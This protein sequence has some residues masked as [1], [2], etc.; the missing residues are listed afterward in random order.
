VV[1]EYNRHFK[2]YDRCV[3]LTVTL[4]PVVV[5]HFDLP[6]IVKPKGKQN[7]WPCKQWLIGKLWNQ[8]FEPLFA[9]FHAEMAV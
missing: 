5:L 8:A 4:V 9:R 1:E 7:T 3:V 6:D 2:L